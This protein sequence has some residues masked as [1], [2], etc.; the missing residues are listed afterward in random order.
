MKAPTMFISLTG[1]VCRCT[2]F[3]NIVRAVES[4]VAE[5]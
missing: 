2:G 1:T 3:H 5:G 4:L